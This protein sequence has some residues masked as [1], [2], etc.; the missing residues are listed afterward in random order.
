MLKADGFITDQKYFNSILRDTLE[1][2]KNQ[3]NAQ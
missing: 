1:K 3:E 2:A